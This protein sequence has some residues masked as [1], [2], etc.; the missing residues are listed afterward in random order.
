MKHYIYLI[1]TCFTFFSCNKERETEPEHSY[2]NA[3]E[4][5]ETN[6]EKEQE[7]IITSEEG[8]C[9]IAKKGTVI[10]GSRKQL[11]TLT[12]DTIAFPYS[13]KVVEL[14]SI[15]D[16][17]LYNFPTT[18]G[19]FALKNDGSIRIKALKDGKET[20]LLSTGRFTAKYSIDPAKTGNVAY[21]GA[22]NDDIFGNWQTSS[23]GSS[24]LKSGNR[25][26]L[27]LASFGWFQAAQNTYGSSTTTV[28]FELEGTGGEA[29]DLWLVEK[30]NKTIL[31]GQNLKIEN[32]PLGA[33]M[34]AIVI[35]IDQ[36]K[37][38][39]FHESNFTVGAN[40]TV[41]IDFKETK[42]DALLKKLEQL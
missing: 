3:T 34:T 15:K 20:K 42:E 5:Y 40:Q 25:D 26:S 19:G 2:T 18:T 21:K 8:D 9:I 31:H 16:H 33:Q 23:D 17:I 11:R 35:A 37:N 1:L 32:I 38:L 27:Q 39:V 7:F 22:M 24:L 30:N 10:C 13:V 6:K 41:K 28:N 36:D 12:N 29:L 4:F 14:Y